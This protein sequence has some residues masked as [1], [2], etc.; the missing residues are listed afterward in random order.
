VKTI[1]S[2]YQ[3]RFAQHRMT[4][5][6]DLLS[7]D[8][9]EALR[10]ASLACFENQTKGTGIIDFLCALYLHDQTEIARHIRGDFP[11]VLK[12]HIPQ[13]RFGQEGL[14]PKTM[15]EQAASESDSCD[16][17]VMYPLDYDDD[18]LRLL[19]LAA[20][21]GNAVGKKASIRDVVAAVTLD[22]DWMHELKQNGLEPSKNLADFEKEVR[23]VVFH[24]SPHSSQRWP[25]H[26]DFEFEYGG[27]LGPP[28]T[29]EMITPS[30][31]FQP[32]RSAK[33][34]LN[35]VDVAQIEWPD[36]ASTRAEVELRHSNHLEF[37][38]DGPQFGSVNVTIRGVV[39]SES[40]N[41]TTTKPHA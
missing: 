5:F 31:G 23:T 35:G 2:E 17:G 15:I 10:R 21:L 12:Q 19:W 14:V 9:A 38:L 16:S 26:T 27:I 25:R 34:R 32:V 29:L 20:R 41:S 8:I 40:V 1:L 24:G 11:A 3:R 30:G 22:S 7:P 39:A 33:A 36:E 28:F 13:H 6:D 37:D 4:F 18:L